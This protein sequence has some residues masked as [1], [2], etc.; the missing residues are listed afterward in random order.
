[1]VLHAQADGALQPHLDAVSDHFEERLRPKA[2]WRSSKMS[3]G[4]ME[5]MMRMILPFRLEVGSVEGTWKLNQNKT[6]AV[7]RSAADGVEA[8]GEARLAALMRAVGG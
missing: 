4:V 7:R 5:R 6:D 1:G 8:Q 2:P 3:G